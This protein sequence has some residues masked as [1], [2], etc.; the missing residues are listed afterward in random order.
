V[1]GTDN[2]ALV[3]DLYAALDAAEVPRALELCH[4]DV[5][6]SYPPV[7][8][9]PY[10]GEWRGRGGLAAFLDA[11][12]GAAEI[13]EFR[14]EGTVAEGDRVAAFGLYRGRAKPDRRTWETRFVH[15]VTVEAGL[16]RGLTAYFD[17]AAAVA[18]RD[19]SAA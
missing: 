3:E 18:A 17:T 8:G 13:L 1:T 14:V 12:D 4:A 15:V 2:V 6:W 11:H 19:S 9:L 7:A 5:E 16:I 10:G